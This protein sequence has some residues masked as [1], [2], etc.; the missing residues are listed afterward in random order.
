MDRDEVVAYCRN[1][2]ARFKVPTK[3]VFGPIA[4]TSTGKVQKFKLRERA[5][6]SE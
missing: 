2:L 5:A 3:V 1:N 6:L 4:K